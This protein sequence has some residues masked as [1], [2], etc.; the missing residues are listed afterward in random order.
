MNSREYLEELKRLDL[1]IKQRKE[2]LEELRS[3]A[4]GIRAVNT[5]RENVKGGKIKGS[6]LIDRYID[7]ENEIKNIINEYVDLKHKIIG[8]IQKMKNP[9]YADLIYR[10]Y[11]EFK[12]LEKIADEMCYNYNYI[13]RVHSEALK[14]FGKTGLNKV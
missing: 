6:A 2:E 13:R 11:V 1:F 9:V 14:A 10:R 8:D 3:I 5:E 7:K 4:Y 12:S